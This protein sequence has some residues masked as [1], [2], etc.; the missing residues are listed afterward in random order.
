MKGEVTFNGFSRE[1]VKFYRDLK[2]NNDKTWFA[3]HKELYREVVLDPA[4]AFVLEMA[5]RLRK[6]APG[7][8]GDPRLNGAG[9]IFR[10]HRDTRFGTDKSPFKTHLGILL[11]EGEGKKVERSG[12]YVHLEPPNLMLGVGVY[13]FTKEN[14]ERYRKAATSPRSG[15]LL[16][17]AVKAIESRGYEVGGSHYK[18]VPRGFDPDH[19]NAALLKHNGLYAGFETKVPDEFYSGKFVDHC[20]RHFKKM[21]PLHEWLVASVR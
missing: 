14:L 9:S 19:P 21:L 8:V 1:T 13:M 5:Q 7:V 18:R 3:E 10:I 2:K 20:L 4:Q 16:A 15:P 12:F 11:W 6:V 17:K